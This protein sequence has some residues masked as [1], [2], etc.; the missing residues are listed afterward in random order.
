MKKHLSALI[1]SLFFTISAANANNDL[2]TLSTTYDAKARYEM[3][4]ND[5]K[6]FVYQWFA[7][8]DRQRES[9]YFVNRI[10][11]P[12]KMQ[13][14]G[15]PISSIDDF[16]AWY[17]GVTDNIVWNSHNIVSMDVKGDQQSGWTISY[18]VRWKARSKNNESYDMIVHQKLK[19]I[20]VGDALKLAKLEAK[21]VE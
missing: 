16:L 10:A 7:A 15:T 17:Q 1:L 20:R 14:P 19:V 5:V 13:Y 3:S 11:T 21:V 8:F 18:D 12:V 4:E 2:N 6:S 9:G